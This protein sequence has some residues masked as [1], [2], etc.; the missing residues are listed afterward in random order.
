MPIGGPATGFWLIGNGV[1]PHVD[2]RTDSG[3][4]VFHLIKKDYEK[5]KNIVKPSIKKRQSIDWRQLMVEALVT[6]ITSTIS[7]ILVYLIVEMI[8]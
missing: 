8:K 4:F 6:V 1:S 5:I 3:V 7:G 2:W